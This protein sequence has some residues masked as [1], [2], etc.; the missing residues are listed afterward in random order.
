MSVTP[1]LAVAAV[2]LALAAAPAAAADPPAGQNVALPFPAKAPLV[3]QIH[4]HQRTKARLLKTLEALPPA[5]GGK[6]RKA[7]EDGL[8]QALEGRD[9][10]A[11][12]GDA[13]WFVVVHDVTTFGDDHPAVAGIIPVKGY[14]EFKK[15]A[16]TADEQKSVEKAGDGVESFKAAGGDTTLYLAE[17]KGHVVVTPNKET[18]ESYTGKYTPAQSGSMGPEL[19]ASFLAADVALFVNMDVINDLYGEKI[20][21][22]KQLIDFALGQ[23][24]QGGMIPGLNK[25]QLEV[26]KVALQG[27]VQAIEDGKGLVVAAEFRPEG[28]NLRLQGRFAEDSTSATALKPEVPGP[29]GELAKLPK[30]LSAYGG[31]KFGAKLAALWGQF[32]QEF[33]APDDDEEAAG[34]IEKLQAEVQAAG[35]GTTYTASAAPDKGLTLTGY[36]DAA[37]AAAAQV[38]LYQALPAGGRV[39]NIALK[40]APKVTPDAKKHKGFTFAEVRVDFDFEATVEGFPEPVRDATLAQLKKMAAAKTAF[41]IGTDG[42]VVAQLV[43]KDWE[44]AKGLL[45]AYLG[46]ADGV[47]GE[48]GFQ[49]TRKQLPADATALYLTETAELLTMLVEQAKMAGAAMPGG[50]FPPIGD[51]KKVKGELTYLGFALTLKGQVATGEVFVP[52]GAINVAAQMLAPVFRNAD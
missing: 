25:K 12:P 10:S 23:A 41:W 27:V 1:R 17:V 29:L 7:I 9:L 6:A 14:A 8:K 18:A 45:D 19:G 22:F 47:G 46:G 50:G 5:E 32:N 33:A 49:T 37:K 30:G 28:A 21:Q 11:V 40:G 15:T 39:S 24:A 36:K 20:Q 4:G 2:A 42:K 35:P 48:A 51:L 26:V 44:T 31:S 38:K 13:R 43:G 52:A 34:R 16:L 3:L